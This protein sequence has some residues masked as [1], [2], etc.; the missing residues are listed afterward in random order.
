[1]VRRGK[2]NVGVGAYAG[3][4]FDVPLPRDLPFTVCKPLFT[5]EKPF[6]RSILSHVFKCHREL[7]SHM[8]FHDYI[9]SESS[10]S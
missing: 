1:M 10:Y 8:T 3:F 5:F 6:L 9:E 7:L 2:S 4:L